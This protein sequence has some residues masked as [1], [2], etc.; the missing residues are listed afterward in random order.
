MVFLKVEDL[1]WLS[2]LVHVGAG[3][4]VAVWW[5]LCGGRAAARLAIESVAVSH[6]HGS[7]V[8]CSVVSL[9]RQGCLWP[10][11]WGWGIAWV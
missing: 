6:E 1:G 7:L 10:G 9:R 3:G 4:W 11:W 5:S 8:G 2:G